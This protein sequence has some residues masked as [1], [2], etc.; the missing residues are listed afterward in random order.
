MSPKTLEE[1]REDLD[2][3]ATDAAMTDEE[4]REAKGR[5]ASTQGSAPDLSDGGRLNGARLYPTRDGRPVE[6]GRAVARRAWT[7]N[8]TESLLPLAWNPDG[9]VHD[10][11]R[12]YFLKRHC[13]CC[14]GGGFKGRRCPAC[15]VHNCENC[16]SSTSQKPQTLMNG[17]VI[18]GYIIPNFYLRKDDVPF[19][20]RFYGDV[21]CLIAFCPR[22][23]GRGFKTEEDMR[24]HASMRHRVEY[25]ARQE[26]EASRRVSDVDRLQKQ[27]DQLIGER[28]AQGSRP[29]PAAPVRRRGRRPDAVK[30][31]LT[32]Q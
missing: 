1:T 5:F 2:T 20:V 15:V 23:G 27:I 29:A 14:Q 10:G 31:G 24:I 30:P 4:E 13:L 32:I 7:W 12:R 16:Q 19:P 21:D 18:L 17:K 8:G 3:D 9:N 26:T 11:A 28:L 25:R 22:S 6:M